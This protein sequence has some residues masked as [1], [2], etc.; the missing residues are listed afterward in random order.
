MTAIVATDVNLGI[1]HGQNRTV[2]RNPRTSSKQR[3]YAFY[4]SDGNT[5]GANASVRCEWSADGVDWT[6]SFIMTPCDLPSDLGVAGA[7]AHSFD[8]TM[9]DSGTQLEVWVVFIGWDAYGTSY[10]SR[11]AYGVV[12]DDSDII[13]F[14]DDL[15]IDSNIN[16]EGMGRHSIALTRTSNGELIVASTEDYRDMG[17]NY[18]QVILRGSNNDGTSPSFGADQIIWDDPSGSTNN[19]NKDEVWFGLENFSSSYSDDAF[20][21]ARVPNS[22]DNTDYDVVT[23]VPNWDYGG[24]GFTNTT[25]AG[26]GILRPETGEVISGLIDASDIAHFF[27]HQY[28]ATDWHIYYRKAGTAGDDDLGIAT[29][30][31]SGAAGG[32]DAL[33]CTLD[34]G[35]SPNELYVFSPDG[36]WNLQYRI[37]PVDTIDFGP[38][39]VYSYHYNM[40]QL[41]SW[42]RVIENSIHLA[43]ENTNLDDVF[44]NE[45]PAYLPT[46][47]TTLADLVFPDQNYY[48]GPHST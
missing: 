35:P 38:E 41:S 29:T 11:Y 34:T 46:L 15:N 1:A 48:L 28:A 16:D 3:Y 47:S 9:H 18:R 4:M 37:T 40:D 14:Y 27:Y 42:S 45:I 43:G 26:W 2:F 19:Q 24:S 44:Y 6:N 12:P 36:S 39:H 10:R 32:W 20:I 23:A 7:E 21:Y 33:T 25:Q 8:V 5:T 13:Q 17:K 30:V 22:T 31:L